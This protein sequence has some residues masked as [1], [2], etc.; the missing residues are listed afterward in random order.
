MGLATAWRHNQ[1]SSIFDEG[2]G[3]E[4][5]RYCAEWFRE[6]VQCGMSSKSFPRSNLLD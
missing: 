3:E 1:R 6:R 2:L 5:S 4:S